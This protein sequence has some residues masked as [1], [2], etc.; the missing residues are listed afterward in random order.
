MIEPVL[1]T[2][3]KVSRAV[4]PELGLA[5]VAALA[6]LGI[7]RADL[8][9]TRKALTETQHELAA[10]TA[11]RDLYVTESARREADAKAAQAAAEAS[12]KAA[13]SASQAVLNAKPTNPA[14]LCASAQA[15]IREVRQQESQ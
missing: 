6:A 15:L 9:H 4:A 1:G 8:S 11:Q 5:L 2:I 14:D 13:H 10:V 3:F 12:A 7:T